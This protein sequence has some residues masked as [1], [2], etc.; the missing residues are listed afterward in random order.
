MTKT[1]L[2]FY[3]NFSL[4]ENL[5]ALQYDTILIIKKGGENMKIVKVSSWEDFDSN[6]LDDYYHVDEEVFDKLQQLKTSHGNKPSSVFLDKMLAILTGC[7]KIKGDL[8]VSCCL[9]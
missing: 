9:K 7:Q 5:Y 6:P 1:C 3:T 2:L 8:E 4:L